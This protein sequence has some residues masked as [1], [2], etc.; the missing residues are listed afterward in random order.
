M[1]RR[2]DVALA[3]G[4]ADLGELADTHGSV[5]V[6]RA[7]GMVGQQFGVA[8]EV[9]RLVDQGERRALRPAV[10]GL[11]AQCARMGITTDPIGVVSSVLE[12]LMD[13]LCKTCGGLRFERIAG[14]SELSARECPACHGTGHRVSGWG[15]DEMRLDE[16][17]SNE[18]GRAAAAISRKLRED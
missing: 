1:S 11:L 13:P 16:W 15:A 7:I 3:R 2:E 9:W 17:I 5:D 18:Q 8:L 12:H 14:S 10:N 4:S 6:L